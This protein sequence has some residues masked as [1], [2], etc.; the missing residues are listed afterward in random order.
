[1]VPDDGEIIARTGRMAGRRDMGA[2]GQQG[3]V[4]QEAQSTEPLDRTERPWSRRTVASRSFPGSNAAGPA[5]GARDRAG[6]S[7]QQSRRCRSRSGRAPA[8]C[9]S[10]RRVYPRTRGRSRSRPPGRP[11]HE[12]RQRRARSAR[13]PTGGVAGPIGGTE[14]G[15]EAEVSGRFTPHRR[16]R[17][18]SHPRGIEQGG[19]RKCRRDAVAK[20]LPGTR[21]ASGRRVSPPCTSRR[22]RTRRRPRGQTRPFCH[23]GG[24]RRRG[25]SCRGRTARPGRSSQ[26]SGSRFAEIGGALASSPTKPWP[27][28]TTVARSRTTSPSRQQAMAAIGDGPAPSGRAGGP[29]PPARAQ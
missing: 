1:M 18:R 8:W 11:A 15:A 13:G 4:G 7:L 27:T 29:A 16:T 5:P 19:D 26:A 23:A 20:E 12:V 24:R 3:P 17:R 2:V 22:G 9:A 28:K 14:I 21:S 25:S 6:R 10:G